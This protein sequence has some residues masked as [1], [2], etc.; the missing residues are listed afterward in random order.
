MWRCGV[1]WWTA[2]AQQPSA[3]ASRA[4]RFLSRAAAVTHLEDIRKEVEQEAETPDAALLD[5]QAAVRDGRA[6]VREGVALDRHRQR[7]GDSAKEREH[8]AY[9]E[10]GGARRLLGLGHVAHVHLVRA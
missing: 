3:L 2:C 7:E 1:G 5:L 6:W 10:V 4:R 9:R 8:D